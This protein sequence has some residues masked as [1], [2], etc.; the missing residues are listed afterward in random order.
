MLE[1]SLYI[2]NI[3]QICGLFFLGILFFAYLGYKTDSR[4][5]NREKD[6]N[7]FESAKTGL[8]TLLS[9]IMGFTFGMSGER[10]LDYKKSM[11][12][13]VNCIYGAALKSDLYP[14]PY[15]SELK[16]YFSEYT[17]ARINFYDAGT[18]LEK[19]SE[20]KRISAYAWRKIWGLT[21]G[22]IQDPKF[23]T[24]N[25]LMIP[26]LKL[27]YDAAITREA[28]LRSKV[29]I[30]TLLVIVIITILAIYIT[31]Y[32]CNSLRKKEIIYILSFAVS[33]TLVTFIIL[34]LDRP[35]SGLIKPSVE[36][37]AMIELRK[38]FIE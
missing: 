15:R 34:D 28:T 27:M 3:W 31:G 13:E 16:K 30:W 25:I 24:T 21:S 7:G 23:E 6:G 4:S 38:I 26:S 19:L 37:D 11:I 2:L 32:G 18:D 10:Y 12:E 5:L 29:P 1:N 20:S 14:E 8:I 17:E 9:L 36:Q 35:D 22:L 33:I